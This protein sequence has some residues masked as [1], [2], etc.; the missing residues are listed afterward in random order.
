MTTI[1]TRAGKGSA[2][3]FTEADANFTNLN[4][5]KIELTDISVGSEATAEGN[6]TVAYNNATGVFTYTPPTA[7]GIGAIGSVSA[8]NTPSLGGNLDVGSAIISTNNPSGNVQIAGSGDGN[9]VLTNGVTV[10]YFQSHGEAIGMT[11]SSG[12]LTI[13]PADGPIQYAALDGNATINGFTNGS[14][15]QTVSVIIDG[16]AGSYTLTL[17]ADIYVPGGTATATDGGL[18]LLT[19]TLVDDETPIYIASMVND[20]QPTS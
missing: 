12:T 18:D 17:G 4:N 16:T 9:V 1:V 7:A 6:G 8:D 2:L 15:G 5:D 19:I 20:F 10:D 14:A 3:S 13:D 11:G